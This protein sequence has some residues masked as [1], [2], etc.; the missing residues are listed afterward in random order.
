METR[1][2]KSEEYRRRDRVEEKSKRNDLDFKMAMRRQQFFYHPLLPTLLQQI[3][4][5]TVQLFHKI[6]Y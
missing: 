1:K 5:T 4:I 3:Y 2:A 6:A